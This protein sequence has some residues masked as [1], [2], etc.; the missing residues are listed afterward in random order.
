MTYTPPSKQTLLKATID[1]QQVFNGQAKLYFPPDYKTLRALIDKLEDDY[2]NEVKGKGGWRLTTP[3]PDQ[4]RLDQIACIAQ[5]SLNLP[6]ISHDESILKQ[7]H[8]ILLGA[9]FYRYLRIESSYASG[10]GIFGS[11]D[12]SALKIVLAKLL[13]ITTA[14]VLDSQTIVSCCGEYL[15]YL[16]QNNNSERYSY[17]KKDTNFFSNLEAII[18]PA[19]LEA[20]PINDKIQYILFVQSVP[21]LLSK[22]EKVINETV[23]APLLVRLAEKLKDKSP[24]DYKD[25]RLCANDLNLEKS[26]DGFFEDHFLPDDLEITAETLDEFKADINNKMQVM[27][28]YALLGA[29]VMCI[30]KCKPSTSSEL[31]SPLCAALQFSIG[32]KMGNLLDNKSKTLALSALKHF[33][34][35]SGELPL[36]LGAWGGLG[37]FKAELIRQL[38]AAQNQHEERSEITFN[39]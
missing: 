37:L 4:T 10:Y 26:L 20:K 18:E 36:N 6:E 35:L 33:V 3:T 17:I 5:L 16:K 22:Y 31:P 34:E 32:A 29:Y 24:L 2:I 11:A 1:L 38:E 15:N 7:A 8:M 30:E 9:L 27:Y 19:K 13:N 25:V 28:Q 39:I 14:N 23:S 12:N 21:A